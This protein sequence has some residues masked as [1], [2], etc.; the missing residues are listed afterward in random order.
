MKK[1]LLVLDEKAD[2]A[3]MINAYNEVNRLMRDKYQHQGMTVL[4]NDE[5]I[6]G[7][8]RDF[9]LGANIEFFPD[10]QET[11]LYRQLLREAL[12]SEDIFVMRQKGSAWAYVRATRDDLEILNPDRK[13]NI[14]PRY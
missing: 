11:P 13:I 12:D 3:D 4:A 2:V 14:K 6:V 1:A 9:Q 7:R 5:A 10:W 8:E